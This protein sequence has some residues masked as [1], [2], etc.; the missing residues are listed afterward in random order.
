VG[1]RRLAI[2]AATGTLLLLVAGCANTVTGQAT[3]SNLPLPNT[4]SAAAPSSSTAAA[5]PSKNA[6]G[7]LVKK[8]GEPAGLTDLA[9]GGAVVMTFTID[10]VQ[11][12]LQCDTSFAQ[13][14][15]NGHFLGVHFRATTANLSAVSQHTT[16]TA[17]NFQFID[18]QGLTHATGG[19]LP[20]SEC[21]KDSEKF[22]ESGGGANQ[23]DAG[24]IV[25]DQPA[26]S[27]TLIFKFDPGPP[28]GWEWSF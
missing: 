21:L 25:L 19:S 14:P 15:E 7:N 10:S 8:L 17:S 5:S 18:P 22:P 3:H 26:A 13:K 2:P 28:N 27:G 12:D 6:R 20:A 1:T 11:P 24:I 9:H 23:Q 16:V 4:T